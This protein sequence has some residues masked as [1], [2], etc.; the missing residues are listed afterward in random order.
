MKNILIIS[1]PRTGSS[2]LLQSIASAYNFECQFEP[3]KKNKLKIKE[4]SVVKIIVDF[5]AAAEAAGYNP[6]NV[7]DYYTDLIEKFDK[8]ILLSRRNIKEQSEAFW[9]LLHMSGGAFD[10]KWN[11]NDLPKDLKELKSYKDRY[12]KLLSQKQMLLDISKKCN[13]KINYYEDVYKNK[14]LLEN[15]KLD[16]EYF[17]PQYKLR[18]SKNQSLLW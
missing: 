13:I 17:K 1:E 6:T 7:I 2:N 16:L 18:V 11:P 9:A 15:I 14:K 5:G 4:N 3:D 10:V 8:T 12:N